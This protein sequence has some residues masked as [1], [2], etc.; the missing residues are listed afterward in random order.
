MKKTFTLIEL[1]VVIAI[2]AILAAML[3]PALNQARTRA[4]SADC[5]ARSKQL[6]YANI[7][8]AGDNQDFIAY[9]TLGSDGASQLFAN[10][11]QSIPQL[12]E[13]YLGKTSWRNGG[14][15]EEPDKLWECPLIP[16]YSGTSWTT[17]FYCSKWL[18][19]YLYLTKNAQSSRKLTRVVDVSKKI[20]L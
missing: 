11:K 6:G 4:K 14:K 18:N 9:S 20:R 19:G 8:Y 5:I 3:L 15:N 7:M 1:L 2:I 17:S 10:S 16:R 12:L 13:K